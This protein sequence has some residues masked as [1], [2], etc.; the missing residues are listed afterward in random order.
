MVSLSYAYRL[1]KTT[2]SNIIFDTCQILWDKLSSVYLQ[3]PNREKW[4]ECAK[5]FEN[6][7][8]LPN[9]IGAIDGKHVLIQVIIQLLWNVT[10]TLL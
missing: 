5:T 10:N 1:G 8:Q 3:Q 9:C 7:W 2:V 4:L 6:N